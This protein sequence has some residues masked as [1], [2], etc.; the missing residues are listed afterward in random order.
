[1]RTD[2]IISS[3]KVTASYKTDCN[4]NKIN[5]FVLKTPQSYTDHNIA[6]N[7]GQIILYL[8]HVTK[9]QML[10]LYK[11]TDCNLLIHFQ[12]VFGPRERGR[13]FMGI[14]TRIYTNGR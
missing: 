9:L 6:C 1:M 14:T 10:L 13:D 11:V 4:N 12:K 2:I 3:Y 7:I 5:D 8:G